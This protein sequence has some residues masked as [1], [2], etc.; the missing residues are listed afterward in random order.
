[1]ASSDGIEDRRN[2]DG[3][4]EMANARSLATREP[5]KHNEQQ[6][7][8]VSIDKKNG[9]I[10]MRKTYAAALLTILT[11]QVQAIDDN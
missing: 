7:D 11:G 3:K 1:M 9:E 2:R 4:R 6:L 5:M 8:P 10:Q